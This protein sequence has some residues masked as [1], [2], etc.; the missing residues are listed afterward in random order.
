MFADPTDIQFPI[1]SSDRLVT[2]LLFAGLLH[3]IFILGI[4]FVENKT[5]DYSLKSKL[6]VTM[7]TGQE[8]AAPKKAQYLAQINQQG[9]GNS[10]EFTRLRQAGNTAASIENVGLDIG[11]DAVDQM[12]S[13]QKALAPDALEASVQHAQAE[14]IKQSLNVTYRYASAPQVAVVSEPNPLKIAKKLD[15]QQNT[16]NIGSD[17]VRQAQTQTTPQPEPEKRISVNTRS[18]VYA[19]YLYQ[20]RL[21]VEEVGNQNFPPEI[22]RRQIYGDVTIEVAINSDGT[23]L[24]AKV[25]KPAK[26]SLLNATAVRVLKLS[27]P[28]PAFSDEMK[29]QS[30]T[31]R[32]AWKWRFLPGDDGVPVQSGKVYAD[33]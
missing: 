17:K 21:R 15:P 24:E 10:A 3:G 8:T 18:A 13:T 25:I 32:F 9:E 29:R 1:T 4:G 26:Q 27:A 11:R 12:P 28:F 5:P 2:T 30:S 31:I 33:G 16:D 6:E 7:I 14:V 22:L 19:P 23:L 20:W